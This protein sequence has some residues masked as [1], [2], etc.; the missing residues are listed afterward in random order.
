MTLW[1]DF[2]SHC[3]ACFVYSHFLHMNRVYCFKYS[4]KNSTL[5]LGNGSVTPSKSNAFYFYSFQINEEV[6]TVIFSA[7]FLP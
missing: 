5:Y 3:I 7:E 4:Y 6:N 1:N 2:F